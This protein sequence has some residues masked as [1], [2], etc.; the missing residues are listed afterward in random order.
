MIHKTG[1]TRTLCITFG[2]ALLFTTPLFAQIP[3]FGAKGGVNL[4]SQRN[5]SDD[6]S[7]GGLKSL[8]GI[9]AGVFATFPVTSWLE[10]QPE[11]LYAMKGARVDEGGI[12]ASVVVDYLEVPALARFSRRGGR[13][14]YYAAGGPYT[15]FQLRARTRTKF[16]RATEE[17]DIGDQVERVDFGMAVGGGAEFGSLVV[18]G[19][20]THGLKD[21]DKDKSDSVK[22]T[23]RAV[24]ITLGFRF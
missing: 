18:D 22:V 1:I 15:A 10:L 14:G 8:P 17:I 3:G 16:A 4:A 2:L 23:N 19:R 7:E 11:A 5:T 6:G 9:V 20:Y 13:F 12:D 24:S 21:I